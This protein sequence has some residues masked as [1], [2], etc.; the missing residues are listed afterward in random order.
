[1]RIIA[2]RTLMQFA[3]SLSRGERQK[4]LEA[5]LKSWFHEV[6]RARWSN[7]DE[8]KQSYRTASILSSDRVVFNIKGNAY[9]LITAVDYE[10]QIVFVKWIGTH[11]DYDKIDAKTV[12]YGD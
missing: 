12:R 11:A 5:A 2:R 8:L 10:R 4:A 1:M 7:S 6:H 3:E 9:R